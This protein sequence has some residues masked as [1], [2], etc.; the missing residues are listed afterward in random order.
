MNLLQ[1]PAGLD[2]FDETEAGLRTAFQKLWNDKD[3]SYLGAYVAT[4]AKLPNYIDPRDKPPEGDPTPVPWNGFPKLMSRWFGD[5]TSD[6]AREQ[7]E[8]G[9]D[10]LATLVYWLQ[11]SA[12]DPDKFS[13]KSCSPHQLPYF[14]EIYGKHV[15]QLARPR[16]LVNPDGTL[17]AEIV[18]KH[19]QQDEYCEWHAETDANGKLL[20]LTFTAEPPDYW[21]ALA[22]VSRD[23][24]VRLYQKLVSPQV[25]EEDLFFQAPVAAIGI[26]RHGKV[27]WTIVAEKNEYNPLNVWTTSKGIMH[28]THPAN[29]LGAEVNLAKDASKVR[30]CDALP[31]P[32]PAEPSAE[33]RRIA[34]AQYGGINR[35]SDPL[36]GLGV[37]DVVNAG[38]K[39]SLTDPV[40]LYIAKCDL[41]SLKGPKGEA[42]VGA[43]SVVR[44]RDDINEPSMLR[45]R[46]ETPSGLAFKLG[47][48]TLANRPLRRGG[49]VARLITMAL[50]VQTYTDAADKTAAPCE[51]MACR[52]AAHKNLFV[53]GPTQGCPA[54]THPIWLLE[55]PYIEK[56]ATTQ[57]AFS[58]D[59]K[60]FK[61]M[62]EV[63]N[64]NFFSVTLPAAENVGEQSEVLTSHSQVERPTPS[65]AP[66][67]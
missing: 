3:G 32:T 26:N 31:P 51:G 57:F 38:I 24:V 2:D 4:A 45:I 1:A 30:D 29:T 34:C 28:L 60:L 63:G 11:P 27:S 62:K 61:V 10:A 33:L 40:G 8:A 43:V 21:M 16:R 18:E 15:L 39:L 25:R 48:C 13:L 46:V 55:T 67:L 22:E 17:G 35:S 66:R 50:Y 37:G 56:A 54:E 42:I 20:S 12:D 14:A 53:P 49:Q 52:N 23:K 58:G 44:G 64:A 36:I 9:A 5:E 6:D 7:A 47:D 65:R 59:E 19:R 41:T